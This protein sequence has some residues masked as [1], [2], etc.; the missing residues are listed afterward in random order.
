MTVGSPS[1]LME[2][3]RLPFTIKGVINRALARSNVLQEM[4]LTVHAHTFYQLKSRLG[5]IFM[6]VYGLNF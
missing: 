4:I 5:L 6:P 1:L 3:L 2:E